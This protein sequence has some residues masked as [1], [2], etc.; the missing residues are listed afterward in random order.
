MAT[1]KKNYLMP[2]VTLTDDPNV[3]R[4]LSFDPGT[5]NMGV[6]VVE[7]DKQTEEVSVLANAV[8][9]NPLHDLTRFNEELPLFIKEVTQWVDTFK[10]SYIAAERFQTRGLLGSTIEAVS[11]MIGCL[12]VFGLPMILPI[13]STWKNKFQRRFKVKLKEQYKEIR[14]APH[15]LD[16][17]LIGL[18]A[19]EQVL[20]KVLPATFDDMVAQATDRSLMP[21]KREKPNSKFDDI[22]DLYEDF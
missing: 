20:D 9:V 4:V 1:K 18:F 17:S 8:L 13:A 14:I 22:A 11:M 6:A 19:C 2:E 10:P 21:L 15:Q 5:A 12:T 7:C 16:A 3:F